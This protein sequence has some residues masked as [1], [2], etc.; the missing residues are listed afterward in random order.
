M[1]RQGG[2]TFLNKLVAADINPW[3]YN[4]LDPL[5]D[6]E[7]A[8]A[9]KLLRT[10]QNLLQECDG[11]HAYPHKYDYGRACEKQGGTKGCYN[12]GLWFGD[13]PP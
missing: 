10:D 7:G 11:E 12:Y 8:K 13:L 2:T 5:W 9:G 3:K 6:T 1:E 4:K